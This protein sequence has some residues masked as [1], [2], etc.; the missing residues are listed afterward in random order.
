MFS[1]LKN[2]QLHITV[3]FIHI[4]ISV[5]LFTTNRYRHWP[6]ITFNTDHVNMQHNRGK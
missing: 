6:E 5:N 2:L 1:L 4:Q 3:H